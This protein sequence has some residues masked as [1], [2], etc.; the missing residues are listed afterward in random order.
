MKK[1]ISINQRQV[2]NLGTAHE[3]LPLIY[4]LTDEAQKEVRVLT[5]RIE[6]LKSAKVAV[7]VD[8]EDQINRIVDNWQKKVE[9]LGATPKGLW[10]ADFDNGDGYYCWK[11]P[12][13]IIS[14]SHGYHEGFSG[15]RKITTSNEQS[16]TC[17]EKNQKNPKGYPR[18][19][20]TEI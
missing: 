18:D 10:L 8:L 12:E 11:F 14:F 13:T 16:E 4:R 1:I 7:T 20:Q 3:L 5:N 15:R 6:A 2:F 17:E 19:L 9:K